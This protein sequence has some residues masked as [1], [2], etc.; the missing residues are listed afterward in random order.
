[1]ALLNAANCIDSLATPTHQYQCWENL[2]YCDTETETEKERNRKKTKSIIQFA[3]ENCCQTNLLN[4]KQTFVSIW[5]MRIFVSRSNSTNTILFI[6][7]NYI[8]YGIISHKPD[9][10]LIINFKWT[11]NLMSG[12][13][14]NNNWWL[15]CNAVF[16]HAC[17]AAEWQCCTTESM[18][19]VCMNNTDT[20]TSHEMKYFR[21]WR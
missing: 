3:I 8:F 20:S 7:L 13:S 6:Y 4:K 10:A 9:T 14:N 15:K 11:H 18:T 12:L 19:V 17:R 5:W 16:T 2:L 1:M 21:G